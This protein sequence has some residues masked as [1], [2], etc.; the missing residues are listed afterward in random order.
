MTTTEAAIRSTLAGDLYI[1]VGEQLGG[2]RTSIRAYYI[3][4]VCWIWGGWLVVIAGALFALSQGR[5]SQNRM[6]VESAAPA[7][8]RPS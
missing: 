8:A 6:S 4:L 1:V 7:Q 2:S 3:P 5:S